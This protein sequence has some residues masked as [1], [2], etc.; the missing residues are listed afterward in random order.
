[1]YGKIFESMFTGSM[2]GSGSH[3][4]AV[5][6]FVI[7]NTKQ[8][9]Y[10]EINPVLLAA[11]LGETPDRIESAIEH[12]C[13]PDP[14]S[15]SKIEDGR[16][17]VKVGEFAYKVP[18]HEHYRNV[19][20]DDERRAYFRD[21]K[22]EQRAR[23]KKNS[24]HA[25]NHVSKTVQDKSTASTHTDTESYT[26]TIP[27]NP[28]GGGG[29]RKSNL[30]TTEAAITVARLFNRKLTTPWS[31]QEV[32]AFKKLNPIDPEDLALV[33]RYYAQERSKGEDGIHRRDLKT[34]LNNYS[35][36]VDRAKA[37][38]IKPNGAERAKPSVEPPGKTEWL[39]EHYP[40]AEAVKP[41]AEWP[42]NVRQEFV[43]DHPELKFSG[44]SGT[45]Y[46]G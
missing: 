30:P 25:S 40:D 11:V 31:D 16:R 13:A 26:N 28:P 45:R 15:R 21:K 3:V 39:S 17:L 34:F 18:T 42:L 5:W 12:L 7:A 27:P 32:R 43:K 24:P 44:S 41:F 35:G 20:S 36:E 10:V 37:A 14:R 46:T 19:R 29:A 9:G 8:D 33:V 1:M 4:F 23:E 38:K 22:R 2:V 6:S